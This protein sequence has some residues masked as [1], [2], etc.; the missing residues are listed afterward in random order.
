MN[1]EPTLNSVPLFAVHLK[2]DEDM[3]VKEELLFLPSQFFSEIAKKTPADFL[4]G[5]LACPSQYV[6]DSKPDNEQLDYIKDLAKY[7]RKSIKDGML[8]TNT[9]NLD[10]L[11]E[12]DLE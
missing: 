8:A 5:V 12:N 3:N 11:R 9:Y 4:A 7:F 1:E 10:Q 2:V 6:I